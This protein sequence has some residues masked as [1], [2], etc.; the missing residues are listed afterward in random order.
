MPRQKLG[1]VLFARRVNPALIPA[2][3]AVLAGKA[4]TAPAQTV[5]PPADQVRAL[6]EDVERLTEERDLLLKKR[7]AWLRATEDERTA[8]W[9]DRALR[10]EATKAGQE[11]DQEIN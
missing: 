10:C 2:L 6:L 4:P 3:E 5:N 11:F 1:N 9:R 7:E 8:Y